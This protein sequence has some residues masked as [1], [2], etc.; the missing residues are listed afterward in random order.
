MMKKNLP[1]ITLLVVAMGVGQAGGQT[2]TNLH[3]FGSS[4]TDGVQPRAGLVQDTN[5]IFYSTTFNGGTNH[6]GMVFAIN[7][8]GTLTNLW[9]F[10]GLDGQNPSAAV[11]QGTNGNFY[12]TTVHGGTNNLG[13]V[14]MLS[15]QGTFSNLGQFNGTNGSEP[16]AGV[17]L[18]RDG[19]F[20]GTTLSGGTNNGGTVFSITPQG[21]LTTLWQFA[22]NDPASGH[23]LLTG[24][25]QGTDG[26]FYGT[27]SEG[28]TN[29]AGTVFQI[30]PQGLLTSLWQFAT[31]APTNGLA[32]T[33][34]LVQGRDGNFYGTTDAG[35]TN[36][37]GTIFR[38]TTNGML[39][40]LW[41]FNDTDGKNPDNLALGNDGN[42]YGTTPHGG[43][44]ENGTVFQFTSQG[45]LTTLWQFGSDT[46]KGTQPI[47]TL[48]Q[49][50]DGNWYGTASTGGTN[51]NGTVFELIVSTNEIASIKLDSSGTNV[52]L[53]ISVA[54]HATCQLQFSPA[55]NPTS[56]TNV[57]NGLVTNSPGGLLTFTN[58]NVMSGSGGFF[59]FDIT[60]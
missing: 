60:P 40:S 47:G 42:F 34:A 43:K 50:S 6:S 45:I 29:G 27:T 52:I 11:V 3:T 21:T 54:A 31:N 16:T 5:G 13:T 38:I 56:W 41:S 2:L 8:Q 17:V 36:Q 53:S 24:L 19:S 33:S 22:T 55:L 32:P 4:P 48:V 7:A 9:S 1:A 46:N 10:N 39:T 25:V 49:G 12:G 58:F 20:Y 37:D 35:G 44:N 15:P 51:H 57:P 30:T 18:G 28:G 23:V 59:R 14:F 26:N